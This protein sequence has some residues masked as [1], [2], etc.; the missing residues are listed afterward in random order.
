M[1]RKS[2]KQAVA[3]WRRFLNSKGGTTLTNAIINAVFGTLLVGMVT[4]LAQAW[5][6]TR[7]LQ[8]ETYKK[9]LD[10]QLDI[11]L[12]TSELIGHCVTASDDLIVLTGPNFDLNRYPGLEPQRLAMRKNFNHYMGRWRSESGKLGLAMSH[13]HQGQPAVVESWQAL[14]G[15][16]S[17][18][19]DCAQQWYLTHNT[20]PVEIG[21]A[22]RSEKDEVAKQTRALS[23]TID[24]ARSHIWQGVEPY[25]SK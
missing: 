21:G 14:Q 2:K 1:A 20:A 8:I 5:Q 3:W 10:Q 19:M 7:T 15:A 24:A 25:G 13:Y 4:I 9:Y 22:C 17:K 16:T 18:Y 11:V 6:G 12:H 23:T